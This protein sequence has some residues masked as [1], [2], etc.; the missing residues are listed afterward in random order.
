M[1]LNVELAVYEKI[2]QANAQATDI[3]IV[4]TKYSELLLSWYINITL[5]LND[6][7]YQV[8]HLKSFSSRRLSQR[9][10]APSFI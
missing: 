8:I 9:T 1:T 4:A 5:G 2:T 3:G 6:G 7:G 10:V